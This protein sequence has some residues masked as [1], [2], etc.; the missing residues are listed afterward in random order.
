MRTFIFTRCFAA[1]ALGAAAAMPAAAYSSLVVFGDSLSD[2]GNNAAALGISA[3]QVI[4][5]NTYVP[6]FPYGSGTYSNGA[7]W[8]N[9][10]AA[11]IGQPLGAVPSFGGGT[12]FAAGGARTTVDGPSSNYPF[13]ATRQLN[14]YLAGV[15]TVASDALFVI[16][17]GGNDVR[18]TADAVAA[19]PANALP[20]I[21]GAAASF[22]AGV[23]NMVDLLQS[24]GAQNIV[25]WGAPNVG[26]TPYALATAN[27]AGGTFI[28]NAFNNALATRL[29]G[30]PGVTPFDVAA[31]VGSVVA[32]PGA[33]GLSNVTD[34][35]GAIAGCNAS[36]YLFWDGIHPTAAGHALLAQAMLTAVPEPQTL[37]LMLAGLAAVAAATRRRHAAR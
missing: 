27:S 17:I 26:L 8:V 25:V 3:G 13:S 10:F 35:C 29:V 33:Y 30:E 23:G 11:G 31:L 20:I 4:T 14:N 2:S 9:T 21:F 37:A 5:G 36:Q 12:N 24:R 34:A 1:L 6:T 16:A 28:T 22:A 18:A 32:N 7:V 15:G 19:D